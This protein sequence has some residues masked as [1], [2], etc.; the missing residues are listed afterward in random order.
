MTFQTEHAIATATEASRNKYADPAVAAAHARLIAAVVGNR[1]PSFDLHPTADG[2]EDA[3]KVLANIAH[4]FDELTSAVAIEARNNCPYP[5]EVPEASLI[6]DALHDSNLP[7][8]LRMAA[9]S[10]RE[11]EME[12]A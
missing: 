11:D 4:A 10:I 12:S 9:E 7:A 1:A 6:A 2:F 8:S 3:A 5:I